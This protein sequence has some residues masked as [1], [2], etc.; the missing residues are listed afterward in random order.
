MPLLSDFVGILLPILAA[1]V[2]FFAVGYPWAVLAGARHFAALF[3]LAVFGLSAELAY[4]SGQSTSLVIAGASVL[5]GFAL[6]RLLARERNLEDSFIVHFRDFVPLYVLAL[7]PLVCV[8][9]SLPGRYAGDWIIAM[10]SGRAIFER[11]ALPGVALTRPPLFGAAT[12]PLWLFGDALISYQVLCA[13]GSACALA[14]FR[15]MLPREHR[16]LLVW[17]LAGSLFFLQI[18][19]AGWAKFA[20]AAFLLASWDSLKRQHKAGCVRGACF[21]GLAI[22][23]H[24][25]SALFLPLLL[26]RFFFV[27]SDRK[28]L[29][30]QLGGAA[31][32]VLIATAF[33]APWEF[34]TL[35]QF[36]TEAK[37]AANPALGARPE[38]VPGWLN[39]LLVG[40]TTFVA[41]GPLEPIWAFI[42]ERSPVDASFISRLVFWI[43]TATFNTLGGTIVGVILP[44]WLVLGRRELSA[45]FA[46][47]WK[48]IPTDQRLAWTIALLG[49]MI[50]N[51]YY[52]PDG[53]LQ[54]GW[55]PAGV[56]LVLWLGWQLHT[57]ETQSAQK[58]VRWTVL[59][60]A[61]PWLVFQ[62]VL[63]GALR[64]SAAAGER[65]RDTD[66]IYLQEHQLNSLGL[67]LFPVGPAILLFIAWRML[68]RALSA[69]ANAPR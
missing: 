12:A 17:L 50:L 46:K 54:T 35:A 59:G 66:F 20:A 10:E 31:I 15:S 3:G 37:A 26:T 53:S 2:L 19:A 52:S 34:Y 65:F 43:A 18:T 14:V 36:G 63:C 60:F 68:R 40:V 47:L 21:A 56:A 69:P 57:L 7:I 29:R 23:T 5:H 27:V 58:V 48:S 33:F 16:A 8:P 30:S 38:D 32:F 9:F 25:S 6:W 67:T 49:Q 22:A 39:T 28:N 11:S 62:L 64:W 44:C 13:I 1:P 55:V 41:W 24:Q 61:T 4:I 45:R 51:P 42:Q